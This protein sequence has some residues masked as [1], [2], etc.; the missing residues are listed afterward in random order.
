VLRQ[1]D[2][3]IVTRAEEI[4]SVL[5]IFWSMPMPNDPARELGDHLEGWRKRFTGKLDLPGRPIS[6]SDFGY[7]GICAL[8]LIKATDSEFDDQ[9]FCALLLGKHKKYGAHPLRVWGEL[10]V[11]IRIHSKF[12]RYQNI[13]DDP[14]Q[15]V[16]DEGAIDT[17]RDILG[18]C[19]LGF[20]M[21]EE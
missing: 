3:P 1:T 19:V 5:D 21:S 6:S 11:I 18:Y 17:L 15:S 13:K 12:E 8:R 20:L 16:V 7:L 2:R 10:G 4:K 9:S 14:S